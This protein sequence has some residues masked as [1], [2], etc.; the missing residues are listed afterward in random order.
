MTIGIGGIA[1]SLV[2]REQDIPR[3]LP[4]LWACITASLITITLTGS[5][6]LYF[7]KQNKAA[8]EGRKNNLEGGGPSFRF[9][10]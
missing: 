3:Y 5:L 8:D 2:F 7:W 1:G 4:G 9:T 10:L 6:Q